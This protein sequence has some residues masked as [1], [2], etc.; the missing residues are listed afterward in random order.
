MIHSL[1]CASRAFLAVTSIVVLAGGLAAQQPASAPALLRHAIDTETID[2]D[3]R[4]A[5]KEYQDIATRFAT[6][7]RATAARALMRMADAHQ[8]LGNADAERIYRDLVRDYP[9]QKEVV[10]VARAKLAGLRRLRPATATPASG[11]V[12]TECV[13]PYIHSFTLSPDGRWFGYT[14]ANNDLMARDLRTGEVKRLV[15]FPADSYATQ[16]F[17]ARRAIWS[18]DGRKVA[19]FYRDTEAPGQ[20]TDRGYLR[21]L[22]LDAIGE[23]RTLV[24]NSD[25]IYVNPAAW[26][27]D[28][29]SILVTIQRRD[30]TWLLAWV[31]AQTGAITQ[32]R[33]FNWDFNEFRNG[34]E[35]SPDGRYIAYATF[36]ATV[37]P[38]AAGRTTPRIRSAPGRTIHILSA[39]GTREGTVA[40]SESG[41]PSPVWD[42]DGS[43]VLFVSER[44]NSGIKDVWSVKVHEGRAAGAPTLL[45]ASLGTDVQLVG[46]TRSGTLYYVQPE[47]QIDRIF[48]AETSA[49][50]HP[51]TGNVTTGLTGQ[52]ASWSPDGKHIAWWQVDSRELKVLSHQN[53]RIKAFRLPQGALSAAPVWL[54]DSSA[55]LLR[56]S[57]APRRKDFTIVRIALDTSE[58]R[59]LGTYAPQNGETWGTQFTVAPNPGEILFA[60]ATPR[61]TWQSLV[62]LDLAKG[63][64]TRV[65]TE[66]VKV[67]RVR[68]SIEMTGVGF[69]TRTE[70]SPV[71]T[72]GVATAPDGKVAITT[73]RGDQVYL[74]LFN[75][76]WSGGRDVF[77]PVA[78]RKWQETLVSPLGDPKWLAPGLGIAFGMMQDDLS[79]K[80]MRV[81]DDG[82]AVA[83]GDPGQPLTLPADTLAFD[84]SPDGKRVA[85]ERTI[86][87]DG[88]LAALDLPS[89]RKARPR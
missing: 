5:I 34:P 28:D 37:E 56:M 6:T 47:A 39:D 22:T 57:S 10:S 29:Q 48:I 16:R 51:E 70:W 18:R 36:T 81:A 9:E 21:V 77:G 62:A 20:V 11:S 12:C 89:L 38:A 4:G 27:A 13:G 82:R 80:L 42:A 30:L 65:L 45:K 72:F 67:L 84:I 74:T 40:R 17:R 75:G 76:N 43:A 85:Y 46:T 55:V 44:D 15:S 24:D 73:A 71:E 7:D 86:P 88:E 61:T 32:L 59:A 69:A 87:F 58:V 3:I 2:G 52:Y 64:P 8:K 60:S 50:A 78:L 41:L 83:L 53:G 79:W 26:S 63:E 14:A 31:S 66:L 68:A 33:S 35:L 54:P 19:F 23:P 25:F 1:R 49:P